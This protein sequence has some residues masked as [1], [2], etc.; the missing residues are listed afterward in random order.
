MADFVICAQNVA[1]TKRRADLIEDTPGSTM[2]SQSA[3]RLMELSTQHRLIL[4]EGSRRQPLVG[5]DDMDP[6]IDCSAGIVSKSGTGSYT[7]L[8]RQQAMSTKHECR[9][10]GSG[11]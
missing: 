11:Q 1:V 10:L 4:A 5:R 2:L 6:H 9:F 3:T 7:S 8:P